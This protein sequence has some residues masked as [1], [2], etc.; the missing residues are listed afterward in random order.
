MAGQLSAASS[1]A[2]QIVMGLR[3]YA[4]DNGGTYPSGTNSYGGKIV[5]AND[6]F[7]SLVPGYID[8]ETVFTVPRSRT[9]QKP[10][11]KSILSEILRRAENHFAY[12]STA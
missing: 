12:V 10:I 5:S 11:T 6:A 8:N 7:R 4:N 3:M 1:S 2:K 9:A